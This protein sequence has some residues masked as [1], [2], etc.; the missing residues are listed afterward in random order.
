M[1]T[2]SRHRGG[3]CVARKGTSLRGGAVI[4]PPAEPAR[5]ELS[6]GL[7]RLRLALAVVQDILD[8]AA[9]DLSAPPPRPDP[10]AE[11]VQGYRHS[12]SLLTARESQVLLSIAGGMSNR[13][14]AHV[15]SISEKTVKNHLSAVF[16]KLGAV[17]RTQAV[18]IG[19][20]GGAITL[21]QPLS[22]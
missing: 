7:D 13:S 19:I 14:A 12:L 1:R 20:R 15:L 4:P 10:D 9:A 11:T 17:D 5:T 21:D 18:V 2:A 8:S 16:A 6:D 22:A 3:A